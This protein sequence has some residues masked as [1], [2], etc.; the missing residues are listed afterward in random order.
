MPINVLGS[1]VSIARVGARQAAQRGPRKK[2]KPMVVFKN[3]SV[4]SPTKY[5]LEQQVKLA[6]AAIAMRGRT[7]E[8][9]VANV[10][11]S[12]GGATKPESVWA[13]EKRQRYEDADRNVARMERDLGRGGVGVPRHA[14]GPPAEY[15]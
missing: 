1:D 8:E 3:K 10:R 14:V 9:V 15:L 4:P 13:E 7:F 12:A 11:S 5:I 2:S 6:R